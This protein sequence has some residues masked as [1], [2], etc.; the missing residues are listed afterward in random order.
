MIAVDTNVIAY[1]LLDGPETGRARELLTRDPEWVAP[2]LWRSEF[3][4]VL[5][6]YL[7]RH[8]LALEDALVL[9]AAAGSV[10]SA[11][12]DPVEERVLALAAQ[13]GC[14]AY[15][16]EFVAVAE[17]LDVPLVTADRALARRFPGRVEWLGA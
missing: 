17:E 11:E 10:V 12:R 3:R 5:A 1:L 6:S 9:C 13:S 8:E 7:R 4:N 15:D 14:S 2:P 16:A